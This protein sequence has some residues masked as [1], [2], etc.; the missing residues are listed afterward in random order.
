MLLNVLPQNALYN[1][2]IDDIMMNYKFNKNIIYD[3]CFCVDTIPYY[4]KLNNKY[5][6]TIHVCISNNVKSSDK[7][8]QHWLALFKINKKTYIYDS[9]FRDT[10]NKRENLYFPKKYIEFKYNNSIKQNYY[11]ENC[12]ARCI[13]MIILFDN[14]N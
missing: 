14:Y 7:Q 6:N 5:D 12:G 3:G 2:E 11:E 13:A 8:G 9:F 4:Y 1:D 10:H